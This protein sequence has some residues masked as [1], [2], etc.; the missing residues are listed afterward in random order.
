MYF[1]FS[2]V[3]PM[4]ASVGLGHLLRCFWYQLSEMYGF[5]QLGHLKQ[6]RSP[7]FATNDEQASLN[8]MVFCGSDVSWLAK[9]QTRTCMDVHII[10]IR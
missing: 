2:S 7:A 4:I 5:A 8:S 6:P 3:Q 9:Q 10:W 1:Q